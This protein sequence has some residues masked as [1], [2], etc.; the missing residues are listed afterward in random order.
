LKGRDAK[1]R[2]DVSETCWI[3]WSIRCAAVKNAA[4]AGTSDS[5]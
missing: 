1:Y 3:V 4:T 2:H 5:A